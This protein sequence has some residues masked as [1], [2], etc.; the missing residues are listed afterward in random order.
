MVVPICAY[1]W[2]NGQNA[3][4]WSEALAGDVQTDAAQVAA[5]AVERAPDVGRLAMRI[6]QDDGGR[7]ECS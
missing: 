3:M 4:S 1:F 2:Q 5:D 7:V 6:V